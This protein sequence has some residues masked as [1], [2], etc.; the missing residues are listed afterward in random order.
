MAKN[1]RTPGRP[2]SACRTKSYKR[3]SAAATG[4]LPPA[5]DNR[6]SG[7][8]HVPGVEEALRAARERSF[9]L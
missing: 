8:Y 2:L 9:M 1:R 7:V 3:R 5:E 4:G 6:P